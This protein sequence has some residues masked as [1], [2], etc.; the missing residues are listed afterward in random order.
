MTFPEQ[1]KC[2]GFDMMKADTTFASDLCALVLNNQTEFKYIQYTQSLTDCEKAE[3]ALKS[4]VEKWD[5]KDQ[6][7][8]LLRHDNQL[9]GYAGIRVRSGG[10]VA[11]LSYYLGK[12]FTGHGYISK[13]LTT[14]T[15]PFF[16][17]GGHRV[18][19]FCNE[20]N[21]RSVGV[22]KRLGCQLDGV[23]REY[24]YIN[25][26]FEGIAIYSLIADKNIHTR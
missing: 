11:E 4:M 2:D 1:I 24:E 22:A 10:H 26:K 14:L 13:A 7:C 20:N 19:I 9:M 12:D 25:G 16:Q 3:K 21:S 8:Y 18:E 5:K 17:N 23:M 6:Y 15:R